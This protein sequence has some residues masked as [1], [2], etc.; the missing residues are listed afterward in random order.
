MS[1]FA[2]RVAYGLRVMRSVREASQLRDLADVE[3]TRSGLMR[4]VSTELS[5]SLESIQFKVTSLLDGGV[6]APVR[7]QRERLLAV[8][9]EVQ[10]LTRVVNNLVDLGR[11]ET[12][13]VSVRAISVTVGSLVTHALSVVDTTGHPLDIDVASDLAHVTTDPT[14]GRTRTGDRHRE[15]VS[16]F[17]GRVAHS[18]HRWR[19]R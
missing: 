13:S 18:H 10:R 14:A 1:A 8:D 9:T 17:S 2:V 5:G 12:D 4:A 16:I 15:R 7:V 19:G 6:T 11:L 3:V